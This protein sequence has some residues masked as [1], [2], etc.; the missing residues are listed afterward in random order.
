MM[1]KNRLVLITRPVHQAKFLQEK[2]EALGVNTILFPS[3][4]IVS[5]QGSERLRKA[6]EKIKDYS[7]AI[8]SSANAVEAI[9]EY[10]HS[11]KIALPVIAIGPGTAKTLGKFN[12]PVAGIP[13][14]FSS[15]GILK[16]PELEAIENQKIAIFCGENPRPQLKEGLQNRGGLVSEIYCYRRE[17]PKS[18]VKNKIPESTWAAIDVIISTSQESLQN[19]HGLFAAEEL[20]NLLDKSLVVISQDM[21]NYARE[22]GF[23]GEIYLAKNASDEAIVEA[24]G[25]VK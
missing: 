3:I 22:L 23:K 10:W 7:V 8:F 25:D 6:I 11:L 9:G 2:I 5:Y 12:I 1:N 18:N 16:M 17:K 15:S 13:S 19:L 24:L 21:E 14:E 20:A 4:E